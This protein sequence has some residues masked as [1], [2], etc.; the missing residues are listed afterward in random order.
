METKDKMETIRENNGPTTEP[1]L[2]EVPTAKPKEPL[3]EIMGEIGK[4]QVQRILIVFVIGIPG[5]AHVFSAAFIAAKTDYWCKDNL[6]DGVSNYTLDT[7]PQ[8]TL[9]SKNALKSRYRARMY[10]QIQILYTLMRKVKKHFGLLRFPGVTYQVCNLT[11]HPLSCLCT[12][13]LF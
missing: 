8:G 7:L 13:N 4:W 10:G 1:M 3:A 9:T 5:I 6:E 11:H 12:N 2:M